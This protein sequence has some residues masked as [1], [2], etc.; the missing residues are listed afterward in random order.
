[1]ASATVTITGARELR[2]KLRKAGDDLHELR[3]VH[4][5]IAQKVVA[6]SKPR[7]P[8]GT[9]NGGRLRASIR[10]SGTKTTAK[11]RMGSKRVPYANAVHWGRKMWPSKDTNVTPSGRRQHVSWIKRN[12]FI[13]D[14]AKGLDPWIQERYARYMQQVIDQV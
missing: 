3:E 11:V 2:A 4:T 13:Y 12:A 6:A 7:A 10:G 9:N 1:M 5:E 14:T 8:I